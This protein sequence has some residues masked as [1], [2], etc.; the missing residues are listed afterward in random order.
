M[1]VPQETAPP[2]KEANSL[3]KELNTNQ[4]KRK[5][6]LFVRALIFYT[7]VRDFYNIKF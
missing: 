1:L 6:K 3:T 2:S 5:R 7:M 4:L